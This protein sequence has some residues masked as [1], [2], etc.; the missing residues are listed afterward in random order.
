MYNRIIILILDSVGCGMQKDYR[1]YHIQEANTLMTMYK[2]IP[3]FKLPNLE[4]LGLNRI[5]FD[6][7]APSIGMVGVAVEKTSGNDTFAGV[8]EMLGVIFKK[9]FRSGEAGGFDNAIIK[10]AEKILGMPIIGNEYISGFQALDKYYQQHKAKKG[11]ILYT[12]GDGVV[13]L[14]AHEDI[15]DYKILNR[16]GEGLIGI[17]KKHGV[18]RVITRPFRGNPG[19]FIRTEHRKDYIAMP[20]NHRDSLINK[21]NGVNFTTTE[22][23]FRVLGSPKITGTVL[24][25]N[26]KNNKL[27]EV[28]LKSLRKKANNDLMLFCFQDFDMFGHKKDIEGYARV[29]ESFDKLLPKIIRA[30]H[31]DD[32]MIITADHG[33]D[34]AVDI[35]GHTRERVPL[36]MFSKRF[37]NI[38]QWIGIRKTFAD[39][40][41]TVCHNFSLQALKVGKF[42]YE[43]F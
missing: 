17:L 14:A 8:W 40:G 25:G 20:D 12:A 7:R 4:K 15:I 28:I 42:V 27:V 43:I 6:V 35:R 13:L 16:C 5:L 37:S 33:C 30:L 32:L 21:L 22:H 11:L 23:L 39:I 34:P 1:K 3:N 26:Y 29:L 9:R 38:G 10:R 24:R 18:S 36:I 19:K 31:K 2:R 41:Q